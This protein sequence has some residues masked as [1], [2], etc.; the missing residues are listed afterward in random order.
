[1]LLDH[2]V[3][4]A[5]VTL[6]YLGHDCHGIRVQLLVFD[7]WCLRCGKE[8]E[9]RTELDEWIIHF[10]IMVILLTLGVLTGS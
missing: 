7:L 2:G 9:G 3:K 10:P 6:E 8:S 4:S 1:M 5:I